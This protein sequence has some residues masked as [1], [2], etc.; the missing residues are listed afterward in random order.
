MIIPHISTDPMGHSLFGETDLRQTGNDRRVSTVEQSIN[1]W[2][3]IINQ[4]GTALDFAPVPT[5]TF[6]AVLSGQM[7]LTVSNGDVRRLARGDMLFAGDV[8]GQG[9]RTKFVGLDPCM[10]LMFSMPGPLKQPG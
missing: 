7:D 5:N 10:M 3:L 6:F 1:H 8:M 4:P 9:H 2:Q